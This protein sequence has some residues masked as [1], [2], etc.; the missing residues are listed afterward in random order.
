MSRKFPTPYVIFYPVLSRDGMPFPVNKCLKEIQGPNFRELLAW[1][2]NLIIVKCRD[3]QLSAFM[4]TSMAD[5]PILKNYLFKH[6][7]PIVSATVSPFLHLYYPLPTPPASLRRFVFFFFG[8][9]E[10]CHILIYPRPRAWHGNV[11]SHRCRHLL[12]LRCCR[13][14]VFLLGSHRLGSIFFSVLV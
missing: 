8:F 1:R 14:L 10:N 3:E 5:F 13:H 2:G 11:K 4:D 7:P 9:R 6:Y 12:R